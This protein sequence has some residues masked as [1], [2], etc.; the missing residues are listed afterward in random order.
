MTGSI[1]PRKVALTGPETEAPEGV[2]PADWKEAKSALQTALASRDKDVS[3]PWENPA[4]G[5]RGT[6]TPIGSAR[7]G[8]CRDFM[9]SVVDKTGDRWVRGEACRAKD[10]FTLSDV[11]ILGRA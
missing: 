1:T 5:A 3:I 8:A 2:S 11:R 10:G 6:A 4:T 9:V 7:D